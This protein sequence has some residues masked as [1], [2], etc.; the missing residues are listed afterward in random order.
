MSRQKKRTW[1]V[2]AIGIG[3]VLFGQLWGMLLLIASAFMFIKMRREEKRERME[4]Y[5]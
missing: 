3:L 1:I 5:E 2:F 4:E